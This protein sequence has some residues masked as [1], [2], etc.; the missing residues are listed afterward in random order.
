MDWGHRFFWRIKL[1][2]IIFQNTVIL[3]FVN[4]ILRS[5]LLHLIMKL[6]DMNVKNKDPK[7]NNSGSGNLLVWCANFNLK[8]STRWYLHSSE[9][10]MQCCLVVSY[11]YL[12]TTSQ[13]HLQWSSSPWRVKVSLHHHC[14]SLTSHMRTICFFCVAGQPLEICSWIKGRAAIA[15]LWVD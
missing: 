15:K 5:L 1:H 10:F 14:R 8:L 13:S 7:L 4:L 3:L 12:G 9:I 2:S 6:D 11:Q